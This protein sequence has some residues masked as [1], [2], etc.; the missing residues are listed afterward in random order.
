M[1]ASACTCSMRVFFLFIVRISV[2]GRC[3]L[4]LKVEYR[5]LSVI[6]IRQKAA[7]V[8]RALA[9]VC[10]VTVVL[11][12]RMYLLSQRVLEMGND[13]MAYEEKGQKGWEPQPQDRHPFNG[14]FSRTTRLS[15]QQKG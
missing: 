15:R 11:V 13:I 10:T 6:L 5:G 14:L 8:R 1:L 7:L 3:G 2:L 4:L 12:F 9:D